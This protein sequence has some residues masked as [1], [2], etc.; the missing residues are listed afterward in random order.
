LV[1]VAMDRIWLDVPFSDKDQ[2][3]AAG[4]RWDPDGRR[5][6][7]PRPGMPGLARWAALPDLLDLLPGEDRAYGVGLFAEP[8]PSTAWWTHARY[9]IAERDWERVRRLVMTR[10]GRRCEAC[11]RGEDREGGTRM[12]AHERWVFDVA[13]RTQ[14]L[15]RLVCFCSDCHTVT[16]F[17]LAQL[18]GVADQA[19]MHLREVTG[20]SGAEA[21]QHV[22]D[23]F[24]LW[25]RRSEIL[26]DLDLGILTGAGIAVV[27]PAG[28]G[29]DRAQTA[30]GGP[31]G[32]A[33]ARVRP[34]PAG[35]DEPPRPTTMASRPR[36]ARLG[37]RWERWLATGER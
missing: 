2:A 3:K 22:A 6:Y 28:S 33:D 10:A 29:A 35:D 37:S 34:T 13:T 24:A 30:L 1:V 21:E 17:G 23:A 9:C 20:M 31:A 16:H 15:R 36:P 11:G 4:A 27:R 32:R 7:A 5:W 8:I 19:L 26:W 18:R 14:R 12:E 25:R